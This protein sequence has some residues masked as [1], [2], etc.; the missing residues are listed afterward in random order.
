MSDAIKPALLSAFAGFLSLMLIAYVLCGA[1]PGT[2]SFFDTVGNAVEQLCVKP[3]LFV[4]FLFG[5]LWGWMF[6]RRWLIA[7]FSSMASFYFIALVESTI[8]PDTHNLLGIEFVIYA[9]YSLPCCL[10]GFLTKTLKAK[11]DGKPKE[12]DKNDLNSDT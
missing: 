3:L 9:V 6:P 7:G 11:L 1:E 2:G 12:P 5:G 8:Y 10:G 4:H